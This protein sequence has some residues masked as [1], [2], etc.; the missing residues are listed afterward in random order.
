[1]IDD[2]IAIINIYRHPNKLTPYNAYN[3]LFLAL[4]KKFHKFVVMG[5]FNAH[6]SWWGCSYDDSSGRVLSHVI[7][8]HSLIILNDRSSPTLLHPTAKHSIIDLVLTS[9]SL[10]MHC[11]SKVGIDTLGSDHFPVHTSIVGNFKLRNVF[12]YKLKAS[13]KDLA[14]LY[15]LLINSLDKLRD[16]ILNNYILAYTTIEQHIRNHLYSLF[17]TKS[18]LPRSCA[19]RS[20]PSTPPWWNEKCQEAIRE[21]RE[22]IQ[23]YIK[24]PSP[25]N[26][27]AYKRARLKSS[28]ILKKQK[29]LGWQKYCSQLNHKTP[30]IEI[31]ALIKSFKKRKMVKASLTLNDSSTQTSPIKDAIDKSCPPS[32]KHL[33]WSLLRLME[34]KD[35]QL[36]SV[37]HELEK[38]FVE[39]ELHSAI[40]GAKLNSAPG[41]DQI[42]NR[43]I[44]SLPKE[45]LDI[46]LSI[47]NNILA[48]GSFP[49]QW[50]QSLIILIPKPD[51][52]G[53]RPISL[54]SCLLKIMER[55]V[56][57]RLQWHIESQHIISDN[58]F[59]FRPDRSCTDSLVIFSGDVHKG[60]ACN[61]STIGTFLDIKGAFDNVIPNILIQ[62]LESIGIPARIRMFIHNLLFDRSFHFVVEGKKLGPFS[63]YKGTPQGSTLSPL[64]FDIYTLKTF[65]NTYTKI[66]KFYFTQMT[67]LFIQLLAIH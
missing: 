61:V 22:A 21:R 60:F 29:R 1:L 46:M 65:L 31:W 7:D 67:L 11:N 53:C 51:A 25:D 8:A 5:D 49:E 56:Y 19:P 41:I 6:H 4:S 15:H 40:K 27:E 32:C 44:S 33:E 45:Y 62:E 48:T 54:L 23:S 35:K 59:G 2:S 57:N 39:T 30:T 18:C 55:M 36:G 10:A 66:Q 28:K 13:Q 14:L 3:Q 12:L 52:N 34:D 9:E 20:K 17:P 43:V 16:A 50:K 63:S 58:Q 26:F 47:Y 42:D 64:L 24:H 37:N 38:A